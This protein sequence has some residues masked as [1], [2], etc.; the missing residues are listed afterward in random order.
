M[1]TSRPYCRVTRG[2]EG[3]VVT[4]YIK[5]NGIEYQVYA[6]SIP[7]KDEDMIERLVQAVHEGAAL[8]GFTLL[9]TL[10]GIRPTK[11]YVSVT[12]I[13]VFGRRMNADLT[14]LGY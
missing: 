8:N 5:D 13:K 6:W 7:L 3:F 1:I 4:A 14:K 9:D 11:K 10:P 12:S 2:A